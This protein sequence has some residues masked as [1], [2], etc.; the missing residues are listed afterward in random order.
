M[1]FKCKAPKT[2]PHF[3]FVC[4]NYSTGRNIHRSAVER[5]GL[6]FDLKP[7]YQAMWYIP[8]LFYIHAPSIASFKI[9]VN[10]YRSGSQTGCR[11]ALVCRETFPGVPRKLLHLSWISAHVVFGVESAQYLEIL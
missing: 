6:N 3:I 10:G 5:L 4:P 2:V 8:I 11:G 1:C 7:T 9:N